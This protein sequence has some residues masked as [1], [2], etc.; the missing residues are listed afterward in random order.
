MLGVAELL[1]LGLLVEVAFRWLRLPGLMGLLGLGI[2][3]GPHLLDWVSPG[4]LAVSDEIRMLALVVILL[5]AGLQIDC[6]S[7]KRL[8]RPALLLSFVP[9]ICEGLAIYFLAPM[10]TPLS[11]LEAGLLGFIL[12]AVS[13]AVV[14]PMMI[15]LQERGLGVKKGIPTMVLA[16]S[17]VD[18]VVA[19]LIFSVLL[20][21]YVEG[22]E[23]LSRL[24]VELPFSLLSGIVVGVGLGA[25]LI[26]LFDR[27]NPRAT[28]RLIGLLAIS[29]ILI[30]LEGWLEGVRIRFSALLAIV[31]VGIMMLERRKAMAHELSD[32]LGKVWIFAAVLL[33]ILI[34]SQVDIRLAWEMGG[35]AVGLVLCGLMVRSVAVLISLM[36]TS[37]TARE[38]FFVVVSL[39]PKATVQAAIGAA[40]LAVMFERGMDTTAGEWILAV[41]VVAI[42]ITV[43]VGAL[44]I[45]WS[46]PRCL[47]LGE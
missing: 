19:V 22:G 38:R 16:A 25:L 46:A 2:A 11:A 43:P 5:R 17:S 14:V 36:G 4:F 26:F 40:P 28:K 29:I 41:A 33:F 47:T 15:D 45:R 34:G 9:G 32:K 44:A 6:Q 31:T 10:W 7:L 3:V 39:W 8:G 23:V 35:V 12:A 13:P 21:I 1:L 27:F 30:Q 20:G 18:D 37:L 24:M 42:L